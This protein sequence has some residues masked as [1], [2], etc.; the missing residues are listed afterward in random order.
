MVVVSSLESAGRASPEK[1]ANPETPKTQSN[2][3]FPDLQDTENQHPNSQKRWPANKRK[4]SAG[5]PPSGSQP[6]KKKGSKFPNPHEATAS[7]SSG[8]VQTQPERE[9]EG[10]G[11]GGSKEPVGLTTKT[12]RK[13]IGPYTGVK[14]RRQKKKE[15]EEIGMEEEKDLIAANSGLPN[16]VEG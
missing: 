15:D 4:K 12:R 7:I 14:T 3:E 5:S 10:S 6:N 16:Y 2:N 13:T 9:V 1:T 11:A 8:G